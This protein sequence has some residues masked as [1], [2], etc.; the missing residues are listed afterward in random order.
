MSAGE[1]NLI[2]LSRTSAEPCAS[3]GPGGC[4]LG[5]GGDLDGELN[6]LLQ[7][8]PGPLVHGLHGLDVHAADY[9]VVLREAKAG[10]DRHFLIEAEHG[11]ADDPV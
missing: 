3:A 6:A 2:N 9:Q 4:F 7:G 10:P 5:V 1:Q 8:V 11:G